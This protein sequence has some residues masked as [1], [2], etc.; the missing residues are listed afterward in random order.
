MR[1]VLLLFLAFVSVSSGATRPL[2]QF[3][4]KERVL[5]IVTPSL[6]APRYLAE[7]ASL[8]PQM[9]ALQARR[10]QIVTA[11]PGDPNRARLPLGDDAFAVVLIGLDGGMKASRG[12][13]MS[14]D[15]VIKEIDNPATRKSEIRGQTKAR[16]DGDTAAPLTAAEVIEK[17]G[18]SA[19]PTSS[20]WYSEVY[21]SERRWSAPADADDRTF[22]GGRAG[23]STITYL[24]AGLDAH[25]RLQSHRS[26]EIYH[27]LG[28]DPIE[29]LVLP[30][31]DQ[32]AAEARVVTMGNDLQA[33]Q[34]PQLVLPA[35]TAYTSR[36]KTGG[37]TGWSLIGATVVPGWQI[38]DVIHPDADALAKRFPAYADWI[39]AGAKAPERN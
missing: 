3:M 16:N 39:A 23:A 38:E 4:W 18:L 5:L 35:G 9:A 15:L 36:I 2:D 19:E 30:P 24:L 10:L 26:D 29:V 31:A 17:L 37:Q 13:L 22:P 25:P 7:A 21:R 1:S 27:F 20:G 6:D 14:A 12:D 32:P 28:G 34:V 33:D 8:L 11:L